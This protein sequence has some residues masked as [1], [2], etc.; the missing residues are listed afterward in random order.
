MDGSG[1]LQLALPENVSRSWQTIMR[2]PLVGIIGIL[3]AWRLFG[4]AL[5]PVFIVAVSLLDPSV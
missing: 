3:V 4:H 2:Q 1:V 5:Q